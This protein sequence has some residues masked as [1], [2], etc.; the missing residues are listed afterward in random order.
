MHELVVAT[1]GQLHS[2]TES[3]HGH[4]GDGADGRADRDENERVLLSVHRSDSVNHNCRENGHRQTVEEE[5][6]LSRLAGN[7]GL[8]SNSS[9]ERTRL[10]GIGENPVNSLNGLIRGRMENNN[11]GSQ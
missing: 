9:R 2:D 11:D 3:L 1:N 6:Y 8:G 7:G 5:A 10:D 4:D